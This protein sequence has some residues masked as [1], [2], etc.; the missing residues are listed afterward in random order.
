MAGGLC[1]N[2]SCLKPTPQLNV[3]NQTVEYDGPAGGW[4]SLRGIASIFG[5]EWDSPAAL[6]TLRRQNKP[7]GF[8]CVSCSW[9]KPADYHAFEFCE[10]G[11]KATL[12][13]V[14][15]P[16]LHPRFLRQAHRQRTAQLERLRPRAAG[17]PDPSDALRRRDRSLRS[18]RMGR[19]VP[20]HRI[21]AQVARS[22]IRHLLLLRPRQPRDILPLRPVRAPV[23]QQ[24]PARQLEHVPRNDVGR[25]EEGHRRRCR[26]RRLR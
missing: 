7:K 15:Q 3:N 25:P 19:S 20:G 17:P 14:D 24:Q 6:D 22:E 16:A 5:K 1:R 2:V 13:G 12:V 21:P 4:G 18:L 26:H 9:A 11:A 23:R 8:M 10:N